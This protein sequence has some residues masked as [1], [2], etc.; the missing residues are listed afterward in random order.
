[1]NSSDLSWRIA[2]VA[3][4][5]MENPSTVGPSVSD[6]WDK[7]AQNPAEVSASSPHSCGAHWYM[8]RA[9][10]GALHHLSY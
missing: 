4:Q 6:G 3:P 2:G 9:T 7:S 10:H 8:L 1:M 5:T